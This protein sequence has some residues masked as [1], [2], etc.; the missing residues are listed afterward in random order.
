MGLHQPG[1]IAVPDP[2]NVI[3]E[4]FFKTVMKMLMCKKYK[5]I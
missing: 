3:T 5:I 1:V 2:K 4:I